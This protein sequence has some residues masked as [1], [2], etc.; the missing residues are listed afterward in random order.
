M[1]GPYYIEI[2]SEEIEL[3]IEQIET[4]SYHRR[5][6]YEFRANHDKDYQRAYRQ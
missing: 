5:K 1:C 2:E 3:I 4:N 6:I